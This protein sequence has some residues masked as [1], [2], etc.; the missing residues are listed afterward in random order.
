MFRVG[1][2]T[3]FYLLLFCSA[4]GSKRGDF[5]VTDVSRD[6]IFHI[7]TNSDNNTSLNLRIIGQLDDTCNINT[8]IKLSGKRIDTTIYHDF[9]N[10]NFDVDYKAYKASKGNLKIEYY[11]P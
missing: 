4:C 9:Y 2:Y 7:K 11:I 1:I 6:T 10:E 5:T 8:W 3:A